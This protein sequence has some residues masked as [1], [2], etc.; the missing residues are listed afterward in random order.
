M[1]NLDLCDG[2]NVVLA[3]APA[4]MARAILALLDDP[5]WRGQIARAGR[6]YAALYH[7]WDLVATDFEQIY[8]AAAGAS[9]ADWR[10]EL[11]THRPNYWR[12]AE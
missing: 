7:S 9:I 5:R 2:Q 12:S 11:G 4:H 3:R 10:L 6:E 8:A 1:A